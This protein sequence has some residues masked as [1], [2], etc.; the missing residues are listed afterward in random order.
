MPPADH[1]EEEVTTMDE[2]S[3]IWCLTGWCKMNTLYNHILAFHFVIAIDQCNNVKESKWLKMCI[4]VRKK[5][6]YYESYGII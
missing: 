6:R 5:N 4:H 3:K 2:S 1:V